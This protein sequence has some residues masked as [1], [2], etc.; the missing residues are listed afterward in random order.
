MSHETER[1]PDP[2][3]HRQG[4]QEKIAQAE[5]RLTELDEERRQLQEALGELRAR[6]LTAGSGARPPMSTAGGPR[7]PAEKVALFQSLFSGRQDVF[8]KHWTNSRTGRAGYS[9]ACDNEWVRGV[10]DKPRVKCGECPH[11]AFIPVSDRLLFDH[12]QGRLVAGVYPLL[13]DETCSFLALDFDEEDWRSDVTAFVA[14]ATRFGLRPAV[15]RSRSGNGAHVWFFFAVPVPASTARRMGCFLITETMARHPELSMRSYDRL[16][17]NQDTLPKGGFGNLIALPLQLEAR[18]AG[19]TEFL[20]GSLEPH[21]DQWAYLASVPRLDPFEVE[22]VARRAADRGG[23]IGVPLVP[24]TPDDE[25]HEPWV[26]RPKGPEALVLEEPLPPT[27]RCVLAAELFVEKEG[28]PPAVVNQLQRLAAFQNPEFYKRQSMRLSTAMTPRVISCAESLPQFLRLPRGCLESVS[29]LLERYGAKIRLDDERTEG[30]L[31]DVS[32]LGELAE[33]QVE[34]ARALLADDHGVLIAPPGSGK[35]VMG[36]HAIASRRRNTL[37]LVHR[38]Q[39]LD[40][41][42][43]QLATFLDVKPKEIGQLGGGKR[44]LTGSLDVAMIQSLVRR[45]EVHEAVGRYGHVLVDECHH[46]PAVS[47]ERVLREV[48]ARFITGLTATPQRRD[49]HDPILEYQLGP[50]RA[51]IDSRAMADRRPFDH[52]LVV[53]ETGFTLAEMEGQTV[54]QIYG[55]IVNDSAR[56]ERIVDDLIQALEDGRS[57]ILLTERRDHLDYFADA[58]ENVARN[59]VVL[60]GGMSSKKRRVLAERLAEIPDDEERLL[61]ATGRF[62]GEGFDDARLDTLFLAMPVAW[63]GTLIQYAGRLH[64]KH[65]NKTDVRIFDYVDRDVPMLSRMFEKR[66]KGYRAMGYRVDGD[67]GAGSRPGTGT[68]EVEAEEWQDPGDW[69]RRGAH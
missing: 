3:V 37:V 12:L 7:S 22:G 29:H 31:L 6:A 1:D 48:R 21:P 39:L 5:R 51:R 27:I 20:D 41:W 8:P 47:F 45:D 34:P 46:V 69:G 25:V 68:D 44:K 9:P 23:V 49:G 15:E 53:R 35:T 17:P 64:R 59:L 40:Q 26:K 65:G 18:R 50:V 57:P 60:H 63:K 24:D 66:L 56:N 28:L 52:R 10:C 43:S 38:T 58:L 54:Q 14:T 30:E 11:Q 61:L 32:F 33:Y 62:I 67:P 36:I 13:P 42:R 16:F 19:N 55:E 2:T 4:L